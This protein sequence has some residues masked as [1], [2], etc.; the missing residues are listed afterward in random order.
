METTFTEIDSKIQTR[1]DGMD[2]ILKL[3][4]TSLLGGGFGV[5]LITAINERW[6]FRQ[7]RKAAKEDKAEE[8]ADKAKE[9]EDTVSE[10]K[11]AD[12]QQDMDVDERFKKLERQINAQS[13]AMQLIMLDRILCLG[14]KFID[15]GEI[16]FDDRRRLRAMHECYHNGLEGNGDADLIMAGVDGLPLKHHIQNDG[17]DHTDQS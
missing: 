8:R 1:G 7:Q 2:E 17:N 10:L 14:Q 15:E 13:R 12:K 6:K 11:K 9:L 3:V 5:A 16:S 4:L